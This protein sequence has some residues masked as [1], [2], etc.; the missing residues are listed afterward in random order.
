MNTNAIPVRIEIRQDANETRHYFYTT[1]SMSG[2]KYAIHRDE[3]PKPMGPDGAAMHSKLKA[4]FAGNIFFWINTHSIEVRIDGAV[5]WEEVDTEV[6]RVIQEQFGAGIPVVRDEFRR[7]L[8]VLRNRVIRP[9]FPIL[10]K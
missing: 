1:F 9:I 8:C 2:N 7:A 6:V 4:H 5:N 3:D 10:Y